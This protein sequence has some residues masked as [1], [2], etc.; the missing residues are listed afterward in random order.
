M[1]HL[2]HVLEEI[3][4]VEASPPVMVLQEE[5]GQQSSHKR[6]VTADCCPL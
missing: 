5:C 3:V 1:M 4:L 2:D 6:I